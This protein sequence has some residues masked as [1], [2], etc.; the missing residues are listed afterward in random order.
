MEK[1]HHLKASWKEGGAGRFTEKNAEY[2]SFFK[3]AFPEFSGSILEVGPGTGKFAKLLLET[4]DISR[5]TILDVE[6]N[7]EHPQSTLSSFCNVEYVPSFQY[8]DVLEDSF[9]LLIAVQCLSETP[10][11]YRSDLLENVKCGS[12]FIIDGNP[13]DEEFTNLIKRFKSFFPVTGE[14]PTTFYGGNTQKVHIGTQR[15]FTT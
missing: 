12:C 1:N 7:L 6:R 15:L 5:Y 3:Q 4:Y 2:L 14:I 13:S 11:Y 8:E 10:Q 9:D